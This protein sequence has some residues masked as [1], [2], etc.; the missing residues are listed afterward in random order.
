MLGAS[1]QNQM[2]AAQMMSNRAAQNTQAGMDIGGS[3][4]GLSGAFLGGLPSG[5]ATGGT[6]AAKT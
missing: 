3:L 2:L 1:Q 4:I 6:K 5:G